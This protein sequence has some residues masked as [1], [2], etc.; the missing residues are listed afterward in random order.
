MTVLQKKQDSQDEEHHHAGY[1]ALFIHESGDSRRDLRNAK[2]KRLSQ[3]K[4]VCAE[5]Q[6]NDSVSVCSSGERIFELR[7]SDSRGRLSPHEQLAN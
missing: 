1:D 7:S 4:R 6:T 5:G 3:G 2:R